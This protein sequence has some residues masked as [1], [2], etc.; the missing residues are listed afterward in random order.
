MPKA[1]RG[2]HAITGRPASAGSGSAAS[3]PARSPGSRASSRT[4]DRRTR[5]TASRRASSRRR[6][7]SSERPSRQQTLVPRFLAA[8]Q[9]CCQLFSEPGAGSDLASLALPRRARRRRVGR[10]RAEG[11][12]L[13]RA[14][15]AVGRADRPPRSGRRQAQG[16]DRVRDPDGPAGH[17]G[18]PDQ[19]D[20]WRIV[21]QRGVLHRR[22]RPRLDAP[23]VRSAR[24]GRWR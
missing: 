3:T 15:L 17:R 22:P 8:E 2:Y 14:V 10:Q 24:D 20:E 9:L 4:P 7:T 12:E 19:A 1:E 11:V 23:R 13:G 18:P 6:S 21:V 5:R 16:H